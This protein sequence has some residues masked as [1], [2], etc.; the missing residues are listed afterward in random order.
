MN[1]AE[2]ARLIVGRLMAERN[3]LIAHFAMPGR[4]PSFVVDALLPDD[5]ARAVFEA[6]PPA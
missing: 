1:R 2:Y 4:I 5:V 6:F 3:R